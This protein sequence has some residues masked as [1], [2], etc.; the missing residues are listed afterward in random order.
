M[1]DVVIDLVRTLDWPTAAVVVA[2]ILRP[3]KS[4]TDTEEGS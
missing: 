3:R 2:L 4:H 1:S